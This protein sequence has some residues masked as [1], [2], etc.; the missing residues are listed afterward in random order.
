MHILVKFNFWN[1]NQRIA[2]HFNLP[3]IR[4]AKKRWSWTVSF[5]LFDWWF[6]CFVLRF[7][8]N[9]AETTLSCVS[10]RYEGLYRKQTALLIQIAPISAILKEHAERGIKQR[11]AWA[12]TDCRSRRT[13]SLRCAKLKHTQ[14]STELWGY[15]AFCVWAALLFSLDLHQCCLGE[16][17]HLRMPELGQVGFGCRGDGWRKQARAVQNER[18]NGWVEWTIAG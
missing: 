3:A 1:A 12:R 10:R 4:N 11:K 5:L 16:P 8:T 7:P 18:T 13:P 14:G 15:T 2:L 6:D 17:K 9:Q